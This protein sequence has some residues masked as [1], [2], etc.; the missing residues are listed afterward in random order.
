VATADTGPW[1]TR[2]HWQIF[3]GMGAGTLAGVLGGVALADQVGWLGTLFVRLL[4]MI[5][6]PL[7]LTSIITGV[8]SVGAGRDFGR[9]FSK[10]LGYYVTTSALAILTGLAM[11]NL[12][13]PGVGADIAGAGGGALPDLDTP[14]SISELLLDMVPVNVIEAAA[15]P[16]MLAVILFSIL[17]GIAIAGLPERPRETLTGF[18]EAAFEAMMRLTGAIIRL[19]PLGVFGLIA[20][21]VGTSGLESFRA[22][23]LYMLTIASGLTVHLFLTLPLV[24]LLVGR[25][26]PRIHFRNMLGPLT[27]AFSTSSSAATLPVTIR[28]VEEKAG[29]SNRV[30]SFVL[31]LGATVNMDGTALYECAGVIFIS[32]VLGV[33]L[34]FGQQAIVAFTALLASIGAAAVPSAGLVVIFLVLESVNLRGPEVDVIV[35]AMLA[36]DRPLDMFRTAV[37][38]FSDTCGAAIIARS[39]GEDD[40]DA[41]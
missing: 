8:A 35:G 26:K 5:I 19:A 3:I 13:R 36:I 6:V 27:M 30:S 7:V 29:V 37:N 20:R 39:E 22:L 40:V 10:T 15:K 32:Q 16:D 38:V 41:A 25:I 12:I 34:S 31:P 23:G 9:L 28:A 1:Y 11:V 2:L 17:F 21:V 18:F 24:L 33:D 14:S 4:K